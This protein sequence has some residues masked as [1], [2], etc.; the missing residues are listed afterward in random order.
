MSAVGRVQ[1]ELGNDFGV[2]K[3]TGSIASPV[4]I[5]LM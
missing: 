3:M 4:E 2:G 1:L 5:W